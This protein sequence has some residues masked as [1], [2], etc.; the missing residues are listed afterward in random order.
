MNELAQKHTLTNEI[1]TWN[2]QP[3]LESS[4]GQAARKSRQ[5]SVANYL[6][7]LPGSTIRIDASADQAVHPVQQLEI[8]PRTLAYATLPTVDAFD[9]I[10]II[11]NVQA[12]RELNDS[13]LY[14]V[15]FRSTL[16]AGADTAALMEHDARAHAAAL[17]SSALIHYFGGIPDESGNALS[18][19]LW[20]DEDAA[21]AISKD[22]R[23]TDAMAMVQAYESYSVEKYNVHYANGD[24]RLKTLL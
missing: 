24:V 11:N 7:S 13:P 17:E 4:T 9:W 19:C 8:K 23:H 6:G 3:E 2:A 22:R 14:L 1:P 20:E 18:F 5:E 15:V 16:K 12:I 10:E 21:K